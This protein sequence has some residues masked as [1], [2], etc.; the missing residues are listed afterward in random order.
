MN[1]AQLERFGYRFDITPFGWRV[2]YRAPLLGGIEGDAFLEGNEEAI[3]TGLDIGREFERRMEG[4]LEEVERDAV[5]QANVDW[6][7][8]RIRK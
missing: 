7:M 1:R 4:K 3:P 2:V 8:H 6:V 5:E